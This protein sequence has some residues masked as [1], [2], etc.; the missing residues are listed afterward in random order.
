MGFLM[1]IF[2][3][4]FNP[5][6]ITLTG[7]PQP[8]NVGTIIVMMLGIHGHRSVSEAE[9]FRCED[10]NDFSSDPKPEVRTAMPIIKEWARTHAT[11]FDQA[12]FQTPEGRKALATKMPDF[13]RQIDLTGAKEG[14]HLVVCHGS[15]LDQG[16]ADLLRR[17][18]NNL[19]EGMAALGGQLGYCEGW[20]AT[21]ENGNLVSV[22]VLRT[23]D[24]F[25]ILPF[26]GIE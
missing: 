9:I 25:T 7:S 1:G 19:P 22:E 12:V 26:L 10:I 13:L 16:G 17:L 3:R 2:L 20:I 4:R 24:W 5:Q 21:Y 8:R 23:P 11:T 15:T 14:D 6:F 18:G